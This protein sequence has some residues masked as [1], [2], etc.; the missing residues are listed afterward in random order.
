M[1]ACKPVASGGLHLQLGSNQH[2][3]LF[4]WRF[5]VLLAA[6]AARSTLSALPMASPAEIAAV[7][8]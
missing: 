4:V 6:A 5:G 1:S 7:G 2:A 8:G 3:G